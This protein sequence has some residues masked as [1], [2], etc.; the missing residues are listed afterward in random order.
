[1]K[2]ATAMPI[3]VPDNKKAAFKALTSIPDMAWPT[4]LLALV[5]IGGTVLS[6][7]LALL[8][9][10]SLWLACGIN[11]VI[12]YLLFSVV[13]DG[14]HR[15]MSKNV[16]LNNALAQTA[17]W[18]AAPYANLT[19]FRWAHMEH[20]RFTNDEGDPD[21]WVHGPWWSLPFRWM[22]IDLYYAF[23]LIKSDNPKVRAML[24]KSLPNVVIA[25]LLIAGLF[26]LGFGKE[27]LLLWIIPSRVAFIG[28]GFSFFWLPHSHWPDPDHNLKQS[29]N[30]TLAT[31]VRSGYSWFF[32]PVLA[33][34]N[35]HLIHHL[36]P[37]TPFYNNGKVW[38]L[39]EEELWQRD[40]AVQRGFSIKPEIVLNMSSRYRK[41][42][43]Q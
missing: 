28:L 34:Q 29:D 9:V 31:T 16:V 20:H 18:I 25:F 24:M 12:G 33:Y 17:L 4:V 14:V 1:M 6:D 32:T 36:W 26:I 21:I 39:L 7:S 15:S 43:T 42:S 38:K 35:F 40:L 13:H 3:A 41:P 2:P 27:L 37:T 5:A 8:G 22:T 10:I 19:V 30:L 23:R 11:S